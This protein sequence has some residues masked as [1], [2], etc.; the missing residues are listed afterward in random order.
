MVDVTARVKRKVS[1]LGGAHGSS[2]PGPSPCT[3]GDVNQRGPRAPTCVEEHVSRNDLA[4]RPPRCAVCWTS[5]LAFDA[6]R[7]V[8]SSVPLAVRP[9]CWALLCDEH[10]A[11]AS[12]SFRDSLQDA[13]LARARGE[14][15]VSTVLNHD[16]SGSGPPPFKK[17]PAEPKLRPPLGGSPAASC[18]RCLRRA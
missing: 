2:L 5:P 11:D 6:V 7:M 1:A 4:V 9:G 12:R 3:K 14:A 17:P 15:A 10:L 13:P 8:S 18:E 16:K